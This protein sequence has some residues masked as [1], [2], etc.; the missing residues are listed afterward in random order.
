MFV[1]IFKDLFEKYFKWAHVANTRAVTQ[2]SLLASGLRNP[3]MQVGDLGSHMFILTPKEACQKATLTLNP[4]VPPGYWWCQYI[5]FVKT[6]GNSLGPEFKW[7][8]IC[9]SYVFANLYVC[10]PYAWMK[11][12]YGSTVTIGRADDIIITMAFYIIIICRLWRP[13]LKDW[14]IF[15]L[16]SLI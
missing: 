8:F 7:R 1:Y 6:T 16:C 9:S 11:N 5:S 2:N 15:Q 13:V 4:K 3:N 10:F 14:N 12:T